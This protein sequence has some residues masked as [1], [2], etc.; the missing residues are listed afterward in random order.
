MEVDPLFRIAFFLLLGY[1][2]YRYSNKSYSASVTILLEDEKKASGQLSGLGE[3]GITKG[4]FNS[5]ASIV[6]D[7]TLIIQSRRIIRKLLDQYGFHVLYYVEGKLKVKE[8]AKSEAPY[9]IRF[10]DADSSILNTKPLEIKIQIKYDGS[11]ILKLGDDAGKQVELNQVITSPLGRIMLLQKF[12]TRLKVRQMKIQCL[13]KEMGVD[14]F[15]SR[16]Q[17]NPNKEKQSFALR[18]SM[19]YPSLTMAKE[20]LNALVLSYNQDILEDKISLA[21]STIHFIEQRLS[22]IKENLDKVDGRLAHTKMVQGSF[23]LQLEADLTLSISSINEQRLMDAKMQLSLEDFFFPLIIEKELRLLS[24][25]LGFQDVAISSD[26]NAF[27]DI[28]LEREE[29]L[30][31]STKENPVVINMTAKLL[32]LS[33]KLQHFLINYR[34]CLDQKYTF[35]LQEQNKFNAGLSRIPK[36]ESVFNELFRNQSTIEKIYIYL[37]E[38]REENAIKAAATWAVIKMV[39]EVWVQPSNFAETLLRHADCLGNWP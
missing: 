33:E 1:A 5:S 28:L 8:I 10:L 38:K 30:K 19:V 21:S 4:F 15:R 34:E 36:Q 11:F 13:P 14:Y 12:N 25:N 27:N 20:I 3:L 17:I 26:I 24:S 7:Q 23:D 37:L 31:S 29:L 22:L 39:D 6:N 35:I 2:Y 16:I 9:T 32:Q 18:I